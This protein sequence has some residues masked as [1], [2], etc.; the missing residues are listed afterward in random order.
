MVEQFSHG[1][2]IAGLGVNR[3]IKTT[4]SADEVTALPAPVASDHPRPARPG[5]L[6]QRPN[7]RRHGRRQDRRHRGPEEGD[8]RAPNA[9][10]AHGLVLRQR[11]A[12][13]QA[14]HRADRP[15]SLGHRDQPAGQ[16]A[17][18][19]GQRR[20]QGGHRDA[21][22]RDQY[23]HRHRRL[24]ECHQPPRRRRQ[25]DGRGRFP[26]ERRPPA[27]R[28]RHKGPRPAARSAGWAIATPGTASTPASGSPTA[29]AGLSRTSGRP[30]PHAKSGMDDLRHLHERPGVCDV[31][32]T[33]RQQRNDRPQ[34]LATGD[35]TRS[36]SRRSG[37]KAPRPCPWKSTVRATSCS[38]TRSSIA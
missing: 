5:H 31:P 10:S 17:G 9:L 1:L 30:N 15:A 20:A 32:R 8:R 18:I 2:H 21:Q 24:R 34:R 19:P 14:G 27:W 16:Y 35:S 6:G 13:A 29:A 36:S 25:M 28:A 4:V 22:R 38:P 12:D 11:H 23:R 26:D 7:A 37:R 33:P 3:Q